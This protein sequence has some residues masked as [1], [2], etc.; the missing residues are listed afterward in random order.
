MTFKV[1]P[2]LEARALARLMT[3][4]LWGRDDQPRS[5]DTDDVFVFGIFR[6][7]VLDDET[8][9]RESLE[10]YFNTRKAARGLDQ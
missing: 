1:P 2:G 4:W 9:A 7:L 10:D 5:F 6:G 8:Q 3:S